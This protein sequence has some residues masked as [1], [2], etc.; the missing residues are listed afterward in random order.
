MSQFNE[1]FANFGDG[2]MAMIC[3]T[4]TIHVPGMPKLKDVLFFNGLKAN[5]IDI[6][7]ICDNKCLVKFTHKEYYVQ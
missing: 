7:Q 3:S 2:N 1:G 4:C 5:I 6:N